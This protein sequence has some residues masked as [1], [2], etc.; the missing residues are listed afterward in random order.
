MKKKFILP[1]TTN[2]AGCEEPIV[3]LT[4]IPF[5]TVQAQVPNLD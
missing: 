2:H 1:H 4:A 3:N 5:H